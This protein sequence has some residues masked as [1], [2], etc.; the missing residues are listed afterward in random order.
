MI[1]HNLLCSIIITKA[2]S[3][4]IKTYILVRY[5]LG[6]LLPQ[7]VQGKVGRV[8]EGCVFVGDNGGGGVDP[9]G[10]FEP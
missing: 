9:G 2:T 6:E 7:G 4:H 3:L 1:E 5:L 10:L 8:P